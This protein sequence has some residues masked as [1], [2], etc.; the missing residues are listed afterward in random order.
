M[1]D[2][3]SPRRGA[4]LPSNVAPADSPADVDAAR[5]AQAATYASLRR[6]LRSW[7][8]WL[9]GLGLVMLVLADTAW[10]VLLLV[11]SL[12]SLWFR[13]AAMFVVYATT[14]A[15][16][17]LTNLGEAEGLGD[18]VWIGLGLFQLLLAYRLVRRSG[19]FSIAHQALVAL[20]IED[21]AARVFPLAAAGLG[22]IGGRGFVLS[23]ANVSELAAQ[24]SSSA[25]LMV[26]LILDAAL[27]G[28]ALGASSLVNGYHQRGLAVVG[29]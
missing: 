20:G 2:G 8:M 25:N 3:D 21:R 28:A 19:R 4:I 24:A 6:E 9:G 29:R 5:A 16:V 10:G 18:A 12:G 13:S 27:L 7:A 15:W 26:G 23:L 17:G 1:L 14:L 22:P 11:V